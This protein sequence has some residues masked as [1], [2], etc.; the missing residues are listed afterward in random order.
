MQVDKTLK[1]RIWLFKLFIENNTLPQQALIL[2]GIDPYFLLQ[3]FFGNKIVVK[4]LA[5]YHPDGNW[6]H[7]F[8][9]DGTAREIWYSQSIP[10]EKAKDW[11]RN[12]VFMF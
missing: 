11:I 7:T 10:E 1:S 4:K 9:L 12:E 3:D 5:K 2:E 8:N 6:Y